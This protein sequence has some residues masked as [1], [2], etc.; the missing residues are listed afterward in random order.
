MATIPKPSIQS[1]VNGLRLAISRRS[2]PDSS[3]RT[4]SPNKSAMAMDRWSADGR[5]AW[6][7]RH[8]ADYLHHATQEILIS[9]RLTYSCSNDIPQAANRVVGVLG[10]GLCSADCVVGAELPCV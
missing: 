2:H 5:P 6:L 10:C 9:T 1:K 4:V 8:S 3:S 7:P